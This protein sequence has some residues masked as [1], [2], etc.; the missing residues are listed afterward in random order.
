[1]AV[2]SPSTSK[3]GHL[4]PTLSPCWSCKGPVD[5]RALF[6]AVCGAVQG[7]GNGDHFTRLGLSVTYDLPPQIL[8]HNYFGF[9]RRMH[10]DRFAAKSPKERALSQ[11]Q[12][13]ALNDAYET[14]KDP[15][16]RAVYLLE[17]LGH[18]AATETADPALLMEQMELREALA[19]AGDMPAVTGLLQQAESLTQDCRTALARAFEQ[20]DYPKATQLVTRL[21]YLTKL[22]EDAKSRKSRMVR[23]P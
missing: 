9:Q 10:P 3:T 17:H 7:P 6:C 23:L 22:V 4:A 15:I 14:L 13:T 12:A 18:G 8:D 5:G 20:N 2:A 21:K 11:A 16:K 1:M 19:E